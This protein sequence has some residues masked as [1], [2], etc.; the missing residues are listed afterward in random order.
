MENPFLKYF[1]G[2]SKLS[3]S[4]RLEK[5]R[6][7]GLLSGED[8]AF[9]K[10]GVNSPDLAESLIENVLGYFD[11]PLGVAVNFIIRGG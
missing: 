5:L 2:F 7:Y 4:Q 1:S 10:Q 6:K 9:L 8:I 11:L 3:Y